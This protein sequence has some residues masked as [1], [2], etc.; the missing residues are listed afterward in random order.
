MV[1]RSLQSPWRPSLEES[2]AF[3]D[4]DNR[5]VTGGLGSSHEL[6]QSSREVVESPEILAHQMLAIFKALKAFQVKDRTVLVQT[7]IT[8]VICYIKK[9]GEL[10]HLSFA[11]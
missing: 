9:Q 3:S 6:L 1:D 5:C 11:R 10:S 4:I 2:H 8:T 7:D